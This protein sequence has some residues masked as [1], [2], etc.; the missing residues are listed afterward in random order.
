MNSTHT[1]ST[2]PLD[3]VL[4]QA[5][6][7]ELQTLE[8]P[9]ITERVL[10]QVERE[11]RLRMLVT[12]VVAVLFAG[13]ILLLVPMLLGPVVMPLLAELANALEVPTLPASVGPLVPVAAL[14]FVLAPWIYSLVDDPF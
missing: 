10:A 13:L 11:Q 6:A 12:T 8:S 7:R 1:N 5:F 14:L 9:S 2:D 4:A 3:D